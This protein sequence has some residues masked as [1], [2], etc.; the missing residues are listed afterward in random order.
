M[1]KSSLEAAIAPLVPLTGLGS[2][3]PTDATTPGPSTKKNGRWTKEEHFRFLAALK[4]YG[5]EWRGV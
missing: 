4:L 2:G 5:K 1:K 3:G